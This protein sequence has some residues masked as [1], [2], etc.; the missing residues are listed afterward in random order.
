MALN[1][2]LV[3]DQDFQEA[4]ERGLTVRVFQNDH[5]V[6]SGGTIVRY[7][8]DTIVVQ[9]GVSDIAHHPRALCEFFDIR[10]R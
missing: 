10:K 2:R 6:G 5:V 1:R 4:L 9:N 3:T 7:T 8:A